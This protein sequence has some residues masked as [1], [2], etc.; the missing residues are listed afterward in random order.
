MKKVRAKTRNGLIAA[1]DVGTTK[2]C[3]FIARA[4]DEDNPRIVGIGHQVSGGVRGGAIVDMEAAETSI[5]NTVHAAEQMAGETIRKVVVNLSGGNPASQTRS[6]EVSI[7]GHEV[8]EADVRRVLGHGRAQHVSAERELVHCIP[9]AYTINGSRGIRAPKGMS[10][11]RLGVNMHMLT[12]SASAVRTLRTCVA[13]C[14]LDVESLVVSSYAA[15]LSCLVEDEMNLGA[16]VIDMGGGTTSIAVFYDGK[17]VHAD[18]VPVG[19]S[20]VT[21]DIARGLTT[22]LVHAERIK[23]LYGSAISSPSD[24]RE[25]IDVPLVGEEERAEPNHVPRAI[26]VSIIG[27]RIEETFE[28]IRARLEGSGFDKIAGRRVVLSG[29]ASQLQGVAELGARVL[30]KQVRQ[31]RPLRIRGLA[32]ATGGPAFA[33]CA[34]LLTYA[35]KTHAEAPAGVLD[36]RARG[37]MEEPNSRFGRF[38]LW[39]RENF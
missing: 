30:D 11:E 27:P 34:G 9:V 33:T 8:G 5:L 12:A 7:A 31:G 22:P 39:L 3:C 21:S 17:L 28:L 19:G 35:M 32:E 10:G 16:T 37:A 6:F 2:M 14:H 13:R 24:E 1:L 15:G 18:S 38:G 36:F 23:T 26:P 4:D 25:I 20:H 29:G